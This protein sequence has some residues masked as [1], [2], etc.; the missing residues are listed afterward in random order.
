ME[1]KYIMLLWAILSISIIYWDQQNIKEKE[2]LSECCNFKVKAHH[3]GRYWCL[4][5]NLF[6]EIKK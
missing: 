1:I 3:D 2:K 4:K 5:C 6:C